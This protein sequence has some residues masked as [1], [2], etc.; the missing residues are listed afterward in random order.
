MEKK[1]KFDM[2][3]PIMSYYETSAGIYAREKN[4]GACLILEISGPRN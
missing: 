1:F 3:K 2:T 4:I